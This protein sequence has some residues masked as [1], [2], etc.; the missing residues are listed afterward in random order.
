MDIHDK[1]EPSLAI[2]LTLGCVVIGGLFAFFLA[3]A[4]G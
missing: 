3:A 2:Q 1:S 4:A